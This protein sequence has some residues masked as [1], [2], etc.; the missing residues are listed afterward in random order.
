MMMSIATGIDWCGQPVKRGGVVFLFGEGSGGIVRRCRAWMKY[1]NVPEEELD[2]LLILNE[3]LFISLEN[4]SSARLTDQI[5]RAAESKGIQSIKL[6]AWDTASS[7][8]GID[9]NKADEVAEALR[10]IRQVGRQC[11]DAS[12][13]IVHHMGHGA[14]DRPRGSYAWMANVDAWHLVEKGNQFQSKIKAYGKMKDAD[15]VPYNRIF[16]LNYQRLGVDEYLNDY[17]SLVACHVGNEDAGTVG[18]QKMSATDQLRETVK[19]H[20]D[21]I[22]KKSLIAMGGD[23]GFKDTDSCRRT[24]NRAIESGEFLETEGRVFY[25]NA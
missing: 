8:L 17:G 4:N 16:D 20:I 11:G 23:L 12:D 24:I 7:L 18:G 2:N 25:G 1:H 9:E 15:P 13:E 3:N 6:I 14:K 19:N 22:F 5:H 10:I 21:G